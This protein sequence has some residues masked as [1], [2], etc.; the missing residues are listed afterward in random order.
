MT[1]AE[2]SSAVAVA[3]SVCDDQTHVAA[4]LSDVADEDTPSDNKRPRLQDSTPDHQDVMGEENPDYSNEHRHYWGYAKVPTGWGMRHLYSPL[5]TLHWAPYNQQEHFFM[6]GKSEKWLRCIAAMKKMRRMPK[7]LPIH[8]WILWT[9]WE[10]ASSLSRQSSGE[11][12]QNLQIDICRS[13]QSLLQVWN[14]FGN[15]PVKAF[16]DQVNAVP[17]VKLTFG[18]CKCIWVH[19][20]VATIFSLQLKT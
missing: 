6:A 1:S 13:L 15:V 3:G 7:Q 12:M 5:G 16:F 8:M 14:Q 4:R 11:T 17:W 2:A 9:L 10:E 20:S 18:W 19:G